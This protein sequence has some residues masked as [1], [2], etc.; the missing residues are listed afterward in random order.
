LILRALAGENLSRVTNHELLVTGS[1]CAQA[2]Q[3]PSLYATFAHH[4]SK[5]SA[6][7]AVF[8]YVFFR[9][10]VFDPKIALP[11]SV[12]NAKSARLRSVILSEAKDL[13]RCQWLD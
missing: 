6:V 3:T 9:E 2:A 4:L 10:R 11:N 5:D 12:K 7:F 1:P 8:A 13:N